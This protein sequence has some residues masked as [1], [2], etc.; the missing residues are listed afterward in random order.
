MW[1]WLHIHE[2]NDLSLLYKNEYFHRKPLTFRQFSDLQE[3]YSQLKQSHLDKFG[4]TE[5]TEHMINLRLEVVNAACE[6][7]V[8]PNPMSAQMMKIYLNKLKE[9][10][11]HAIQSSLQD[12]VNAVEDILNRNLDLRILT[13]AAYRSKAV[14]AE[15]KNSKGNG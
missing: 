13:I 2:D 10:E 7:L 11:E 12:E 1:N 8:D 15:K 14:F 9:A 6:Y 3:S 5:R 4:M